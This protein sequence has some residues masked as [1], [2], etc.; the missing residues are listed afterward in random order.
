MNLDTN[1][2]KYFGY[3]RK[4][5]EDDA[6]QV[7]SLPGQVKHVQEV[8]ERSGLRLV[9]I[10]SEQK[11]ASKLGREQ[12]KEMLDCVE[13]GKAQGIVCWKLDRLSRNPIDEGRVKWLL[14]Q[15][16]IKHI[17]TSDRDYYSGDNVLI[18]SVE[19]GVA[20]QVTRDLSTNTKRGLRLKA[21]MGQPP[22]FANLGYQNNL[23][24]HNWEPDPIRAPYIAQMFEWYDSGQYSELQ[25]VER[26]NKS[27]FRTRHG[28]PIGKSL[29]GRTLRSPVYYG[30][31]YDDGEL[32]K[33]SYEALITKEVWD[34]VQDRLDGRVTYNHKKAKLVFKYRGYVFCGEC[35]CSITAER[36]KG[37]VYYRCTKSKGYCSQSY[38]REEDLEPQLFDIF[39]GI[40]LDKGDIESVQDELLALYE[41]DRV[42]QATTLKNLKTELTKL[43]EEKLR[44]FRKM[45]SVEFD[46]EDRE[47]AL[48]LRDGISK[49]I[50]VIQGQIE[51]LSDSSY[52]WLEQS[53]NLLKLANKAT[54]LFSAANAEQKRQLLDFVSSNRV[55]KDRKVTYE[56]AEPFVLAANIKSQN[57]ER[58][59]NLSGRPVWLRE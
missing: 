55:L 40:Q 12:F 23:A 53:S 18:T 27:G 11:S 8:A 48:E 4:S 17:K 29:V 1:Q 15:G 19:F 57:A 6:R 47:M 3:C 46:V 54:E 21:S 13:K 34:R 39:N 49:R 37:H 16:I 22:R 50:K 51:A 31:F 5:S 36:K 59:D 33:G 24:T 42:F 20:N 44:V 2:I 45:M 58:P 9:K 43:E 30:Y 52:S 41:K 25:I 38:V 26:L 28:K 10:Y 32:K 56:Y 35:G 14:Q 7:L